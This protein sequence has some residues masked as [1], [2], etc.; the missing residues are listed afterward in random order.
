ST[1]V[2]GSK[3][4]SGNRALVSAFNFPRMTL[5]IAINVREM[6][7]QVTTYIT[8]FALILIVPPLEPITWKW[9][10]FFSI[11]ALQFLFN[12][13]LCLVLERILGSSNDFTLF[14][15]FATSIWLYMSAVFYGTDRFAYI[16]IAMNLMNAN[17]LFIVLD[18]T[19][20]VSLYD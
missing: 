17:P 2:A 18:M 8:M 9:L 16:P 11:V 15:A 12:L 4:I 13:G 19:R 10:M 5:P 20:G 1:V 14:I 6:L 3:A 7:R